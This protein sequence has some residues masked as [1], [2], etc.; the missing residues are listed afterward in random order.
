MMKNKY[1]ELEKEVYERVVTL[2]S[3]ENIEDKSKYKDLKIEQ[4]SYEDLTEVIFGDNVV[5]K[6]ALVSGMSAYWIEAQLYNK[7]KAC[8]ESYQYYTL[9]KVIQID[10]NNTQYNIVISKKEEQY[11][12]VSYCWSNNPSDSFDEIWEDNCQEGDLLFNVPKG[13]LLN[14]IIGKPDD[15]SMYYN[16][17]DKINDLNFDKLL[18]DWDNC[19]THEEGYKLFCEGI[20]QKVVSDIKIKNCKYCLNKNI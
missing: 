14:E 20:E 8:G 1:I 17:K 2:I 3:L 18:E 4:D 19:Y 5:C 15:Y 11:P 9:D 12:L 6:L 16:F 13:W 7:N 10:E